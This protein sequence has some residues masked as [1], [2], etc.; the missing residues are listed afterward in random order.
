LLPFIITSYTKSLLEETIIF[1]WFNIF[2]LLLSWFFCNIWIKKYIFN[3]FFRNWLLSQ[4]VYWFNLIF[5]NLF[6][7]FCN[8]FFLNVNVIAPCNR[9]DM[10]SELKWIELFWW[11]L[12]QG[13]HCQFFKT[14]FL[15]PYDL[16]IFFLKFYMSRLHRFFNTW[17]WSS[18]LNLKRW[19]FFKWDVF[20][21]LLWT[22]LNNEFFPFHWNS[23]RSRSILWQLR[24]CDLWTPRLVSMLFHSL[25]GCS[26]ALACSI[27]VV[28]WCNIRFVSY[29]LWISSSIF[30]ILLRHTHRI[31]LHHTVANQLRIM[32][33]ILKR[34]MKLDLVS[35]LFVKDLTPHSMEL[36][37]S[38]FLL[39]KSL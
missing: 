13:I 21:I 27:F 38:F 17:D 23:K 30:L 37:L 32:K 19:D 33:T 12:S 20:V 5:N 3:R 14:D 39:L 36:L 18:S 28:I 11:N 34:L 15:I 25:N 8:I 16:K 2:G 10:V 1:L 24:T 9:V 35:E 22:V 31:V 7:G 6:D 4:S 29:Y 26:H